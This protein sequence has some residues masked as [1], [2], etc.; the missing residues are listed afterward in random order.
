MLAKMWNFFQNCL[1]IFAVSKKL[2]PKDKK[3]YFSNIGR[4]LFQAGGSMDVVIRSPPTLCQ[5][6]LLNK[7]QELFTC[8]Y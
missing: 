8:K 2:V 7:Q 5:G 4:S 1:A 6:E 3:K